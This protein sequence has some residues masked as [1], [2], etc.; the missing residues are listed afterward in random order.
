[1][2]KHISMLLLAACMLTGSGVL[3]E[4]ISDLDTENSV[5]ELVAFHEVIYPI[6]HEAYPAKDVVALKSFVPRINELAAQV[7]KARLPGILREKKS[8]WKAGVGDLRKSVKAY[9]AA[10]KGTDDQ[11]MLTAAEELHRRYEILV[12]TLRPVLPEMEAFHKTLYVVYH[13]DLPAAQWENIR[14]TTPE[15][16][17]GAKAISAARLPKRFEAR[18]AEFKSAAAALAKAVSGLQETGAS[19]PGPEIKKAVLNVHDE[20]L[21]LQKIFE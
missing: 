3:A 1:M 11:A 4:N 10:A 20:Y 21:A 13:K 7:Y 14:K 5:Q 6:W 17:A 12:R 19:A 9:N 16:A 2:K 8:G 15:L 18:S